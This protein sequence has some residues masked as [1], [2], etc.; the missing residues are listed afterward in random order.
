MICE[1]LKKVKSH[2]NTSQEVNFYKFSRENF[3]KVG[4][5]GF[6]FER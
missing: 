6:E 1:L 5:Q 4:E 2:R 3:K